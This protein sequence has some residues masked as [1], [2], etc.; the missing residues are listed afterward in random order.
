MPIT[1]GM[2][3]GGGIIINIKMNN[4]QEVWMQRMF[5]RISCEIAH[6]G[7][8]TCNKACVKRLFS[9]HN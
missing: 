2:K 1:S 9:M 6:K 8:P 3:S 4:E 5:C 7:T